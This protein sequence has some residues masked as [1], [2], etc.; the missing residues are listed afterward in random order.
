MTNLRKDDAVVAILF[1]VIAKPGKRQELFEFLKWDREES[2]NKDQEPGTLRFDV[3]QDPKN[4]E[5]FYVYEA[6]ED[7]AAFEEHM[8]H[9][10]FQRW[11]SDEFQNEIVLSHKNLSPFAP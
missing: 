6:Y 3:F 2:M 1:H 7:R 9:A 5:G 8:T 4:E 11:V 10:P